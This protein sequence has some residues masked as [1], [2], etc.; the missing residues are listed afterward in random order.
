MKKLFSLVFFLSVFINAFSQDPMLASARLD[1]LKTEKDSKV[2][3]GFS[4]AEVKSAIGNPNAVQSGFPDTNN[5]YFDDKMV[6]QLNYSTWF[7]F[8]KPVQLVIGELYLVNNHPTTKEVYNSYL[9]SDEVFYYDGNIVNKEFGDKY[10]NSKDDKITS[11]KLVKES[12]KYVPFDGK[13]TKTLIPI[14][15]VLFDKGT[16]VVAGTKA[17]FKK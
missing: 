9:N 13:A 14:Y 12:T 17:Y 4:P 8:L 16:L 10:Q 6:G 11:E 7:Y 5:V 15:C 3:I 2:K 1:I